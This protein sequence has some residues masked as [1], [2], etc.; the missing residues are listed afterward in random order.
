M[1]NIFKSLLL[2]AAVLVAGTTVSCTDDNENGGQFQGTPTIE[3]APSSVTIGLEGG[4]TEAIDVVTPASWTVTCDADD[5]VASPAAGNGNAQ[6]VFTVGE[7]AAPRVIKV[8]FVA[9]GYMSG[10]PITKKATLT[11]SQ[12]ELPNAD[13]FLY[14]D[15]CGSAVSKVNGYWPYVDKYEGWAPQ[16]GEGLDQSGVTYTGSNASVRNSGKAWAPV[17]ASYATDAPYA[18]IAKADAYFQI[19]KIALPADAKNLTFTFTAFN[20]YASLSESP[21]TPVHEPLVSGS[22]M[23]LSVSLD[24]TA[25]APVAFTTMADGNWEY[26]IAPFTLP[27]GQSATEL[28][29]KFSNYVANTSRALPD[30]TYQYQAALRLDD[31]VL[32]EG[33]NGPVLD[34][35]VPE[36]PVTT[37]TTIASITAEGD[38]TVKGAWV[39]ATYDRG[40]LLTDNSGAYILA[41][42][43]STTPAVGA[44][45]DITGTV[46]TYAGLLQFGAGATITTTGETKTVTNP[47]PEVMDAAALDAYVPSP[48]IK[49]V[50]YTGTL[51]V[52]GTY[53]NVNIEGASTAIGSIAYPAGD[54]KGACD[55]L[56]G[57]KIVVTGYLIG[58]NS[59]KYVNT[60]AVSVVAAEIDPNAPTLSLDATQLSFVAE[61]ESKTVTATTNALEGYTLTATVDNAAFAVAVDG[62]VITVTTVATETAQNGTL[63]VTYGNGTDS[64]VKTVSLRQV[65]PSS[66][67]A[68]T[69][70]LSKDTIDTSSWTVNGY[71]SQSVTS[72]DTFLQWTT[73]GVGIAA[74]KWCLPSS[75]DYAS[76]PVMQAQGNNTDAAKQSRIGNT[77]SMGKI[78]K[79]TVVTYNTK[80][81][82]NFNLAVGTE[83]QV[84][85]TVPSNMIGAASM[86]QTEETVGSLKKYT[87]VYEPTSDVSYFA[88]YKNTSGALYTESITVEYE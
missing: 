32:T 3:V 57:Q 81:T 68:K 15:N 40:C 13:A 16:G 35:V 8:T 55:A 18:Y 73:D 26:A 82:P 46:S 84:G 19:N 21:Y 31:F 59:G 51:A 34:L 86:N 75:A 80:Y 42:N 9:T 39:V 60:M 41:F 14:K 62:N 74:C 87:N 83:Q 48:V 65:A 24:G 1:K 5:V 44:V 28:Y 53:Y 7:S 72:F 23:T 64:V 30:A 67:D 78:K 4:D 85:T 61:G 49:F 52:N 6:V 70:V 66:G 33:G 20:Q 56:N 27:E 47:T 17:G 10:F 29:V 76:V 58:A 71:G 43:P 54:I 38:Y 25:W 22:N 36:P 45:L 12:G 63:T 79:I 69:L 37:D 50:E 77:T 2:S 11:I 88:I